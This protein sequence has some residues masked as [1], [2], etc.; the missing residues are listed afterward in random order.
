MVQI[1][2]IG[3]GMAGAACARTLAEAG[4]DPVLFERGP[5]IG[6][7][8]GQHRL[9]DAI[10]DHGA[11]YL[12]AS[13]PAFL[14]LLAEWQ[15][16][17]I[18]A[19][20]NPR[21][22]DPP[23]RQRHVGVPSM[24]SPVQTLVGGLPY[25]LGTEVTRIERRQHVWQLDSHGDSLGRFDAVV[26]TAPAPLA[27]T[28]L[29]DTRLGEDARQAAMD[30]CWSVMLAFERPLDLA[31]DVLDPGHGAIVFAARNA[32]KPGRGH[33]EAW[34]IHARPGFSIEHADRPTA[35]VIE[36]LTRAFGELVGMTLPGIAAADAR[37]WPYCLVTRSARDACLIDP[38]LRIA[39]AGDW[40]IGPR[41]ESAWLSGRAAADAIARTF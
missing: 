7:R 3:A 26:V 12:T 31:L 8:L 4:F 10:F 39:A 21:M 16:Q 2:I 25:W 40:C 37:F 18:V 11:Q 17:G 5:V 32:S 19:P 6:G 9:G 15:R 24:A 20:W 1:A 30:P 14:R 13:D 27:A 22:A 36:L 38:E 41:I 28:L 35:E 33:A 29:A 34:T 23:P